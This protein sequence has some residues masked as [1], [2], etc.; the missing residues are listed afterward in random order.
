MIYIGADH[1]GFELKKH[2]A[3]YL[4]SV[5]RVKFEDMG[6]DTFSSEDDFPDFAIPL[7]KKVVND[8]NNRGIMICRSGLG[9][10]IVTNKIKGARAILGH[11]ITAAEMGR[12][13]NDANILCLA[14]DTLSHEH[15]DAIVKKFIETKFEADE[16]LIRR[17]KKIAELEK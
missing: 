6:T 3:N 13:H 17:N 9:S 15:A 14:G 2:L 1:G 4:K 16:R 11:N 10:C 8:K 5:L 7:A 12:K